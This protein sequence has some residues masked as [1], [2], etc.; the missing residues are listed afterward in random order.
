[1]GRS[2]SVVARTFLHI[3]IGALF[4]AAAWLAIVLLELRE[5]SGS[6]HDLGAIITILFVLSSW[7]A[8]GAGLS[9]FIFINVERAERWRMEHFPNDGRRH[10]A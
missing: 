8:V 9:G 3:L 6:I 4:G 7:I 1:M 10:H 5:L 2:L